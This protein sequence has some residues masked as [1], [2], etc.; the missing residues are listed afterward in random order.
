ME[1]HRNSGLPPTHK[2]LV[3]LP[4]GK[5]PGGIA[6][7]GAAVGTVAREALASLHRIYFPTSAGPPPVVDR[8]AEL[9]R[10]RTVRF[11]GILL[12]KM[13]CMRWRC[14]WLD[15]RRFPP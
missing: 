15:S 13:L 11:K 4:L 9:G 7:G 6:A 8:L 1:T 5:P 10:K 3:D 14:L 12:Y 2:Y